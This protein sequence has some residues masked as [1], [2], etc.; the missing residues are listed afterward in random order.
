MVFESTTTASRCACAKVNSAFYEKRLD[1]IEREPN[2]SN[3]CSRGRKRSGGAAADRRRSR[4]TAK[5][6]TANPDCGSSAKILATNL[7]CK[8]IAAALSV[9]QPKPAGG[10][11]GFRYDPLSYS[12]NFDDGSW[13][14][15]GDARSR[16]FSSRYAAPPPPPPPQRHSSRPHELR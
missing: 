6:L 4:S 3:A 8:S 5:S 13:H 7:D 9:A 10:A 12:Q 2:E 16:G 1:W 14:A 11:G 15:D